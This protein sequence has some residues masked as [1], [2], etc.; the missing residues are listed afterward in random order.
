M[1]DLLCGDFFYFGFYNIKIMKDVWY[2]KIKK[3]EFILSKEI[4]IYFC[5]LINLLVYNNDYF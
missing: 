5:L 4:L 3:E 2:G 1:Y